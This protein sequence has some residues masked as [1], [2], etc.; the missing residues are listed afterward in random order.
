MAGLGSACSHVASLLFKLEAA[1]HYH[2]NEQTASTSLLC[3]WKASKKHVMPAPVSVIYFSRPKARSLP[4]I[5]RKMQVVRNFSCL[6][7][8]SGDSAISKD[9]FKE[10]QAIYPKAA[11]FSSL[12]V[13]DI[14]DSSQS[15]EVVS[16]AQRDDSETDSDIESDSTIIPEP[17]TSLFDP[18][19]VHMDDEN[20]N[21]LARERY[22]SY[23]E[24]NFQKLY[25]NLNKLTQNQESNAAWMIHRAGRITASTCNQVARMKDSKS[26]ISTIMQYTEF[27]SKYTEYGKKWSLW[28]NIFLKSMKA[29]ITVLFPFPHLDWW[30]MQMNHTWVP[31]LMELYFV[32]AM[33]RGYLK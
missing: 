3:A 19:A 9:K 22:Y 20:L 31:H 27:T 28:H 13:Y 4:M 32:S 21:K 24:K 25:D 23:Q 16:C 30:L 14:V 5:K 7:P 18:T 26:L 10:L 17:L 6:D 33:G 15:F 8:T 11:V 29:E 1:V 2:L 12:P